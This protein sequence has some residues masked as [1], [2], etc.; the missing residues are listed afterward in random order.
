MHENDGSHSR[1]ALGARQKAGCGRRAH[2][3]IA[4]RGIL[5]VN[6]YP[7][8]DKAAKAGR[9]AGIPGHRWRIA[10]CGFELLGRSGRNPEC[11]VILPDVN[12]LV[13]AF[14]ADSVEHQLCRKWLQGV[15]NADSRYGIAPQ[16]LAGVIRITTHPKIF[17]QP[18]RLDEVVK[19]C[20]VL[21]AQPQC[22]VIQPG[23][24]HWDIF[25]RLCR[26][27]DARGNLVPDAWYAALAIE[28]GC[29]WISLDRDYARFRD[30]SWR[31]PT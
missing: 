22:L 10:G 24:R 29:E 23:E 21:I 3:D 4:D 19:F 11:A 12:V 15:V 31:L 14:R 8:F 5:D 28:S 26:E 18:S 27:A 20:D 16:V 7:A 13:H 1:R 9:V 2:F 30:L 17:A 25:T 6:C